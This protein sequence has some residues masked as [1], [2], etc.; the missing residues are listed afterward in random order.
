M[1]VV[2]NEV[3]QRFLFFG[4]DADAPLDVVVKDKMIQHQTVEIGS[5]YAENNGLFVVDQRRRQ[6][7]AHTG[8]RH[9]PPQI[10]MQVLVH[11][12]GNDIQPSGRSIAVKQDAQPYADH[13]NV[14]QHIQLL[15]VGQRT[16]VWEN[17]LQHTD[18]KRQQNAGVHGFGAKLAPAGQKADQ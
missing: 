9:C 13:Q 11:N 17:A 16:D 7:H 15:A 8:K 2:D 1:Q 4:D 10:H 18:E 12:L 3:P 5:Q 6:R 14:T